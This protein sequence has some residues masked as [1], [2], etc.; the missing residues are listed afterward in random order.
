[1][2]IL[3]LS[4][5]D[6]FEYLKKNS[7]ALIT[8]KKAS[9]KTADC[10][11]SNPMLI[12]SEGTDKAAGEE[13]AYEIAANTCMYIDDQ[14]DAL[15][16]GA[17]TKSFNQTK[18]ELKSNLASVRLTDDAAFNQTKVELKYEYSAIK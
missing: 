2:N 3:E 4:R 9:I 11:V 15:A 18:V 17:A 8:L 6:R 1:M 7:K 14:M 13:G 16:P 5:E 12:K 10:V